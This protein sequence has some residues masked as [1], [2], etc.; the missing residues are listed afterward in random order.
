MNAEKLTTSPI[1]TF[2]ALS[3]KEENVVYKSVR[4]DPFKLYGLYQPK[5]GKR[6]CRM[7]EEVAKKV[8]DG[9]YDL[10][11]KTAGGRVR[12]R[13]DSPFIALRCKL[14]FT[15]L[16]PHMAPTGQCGF[17]LYLTNE[18]G[19]DVFRHAFK[20]AM[21]TF[22]GYEGCV[23][24]QDRKMRDITINFP[25]FANVDEVWIG[26]LP[27]AEL[28]SPKPYAIEKPVV[29]YGSS[30]THGGCA[31]RPGL[32]YEAWI[33]RRLNC[34]YI[35]LGFSGNC[36]GEPVM[37]EY[38]AK[39]DASVFVIDYDHNAPSAEHL[40]NTHEP[41]YRAIR[42][43]H[44]DTP[45][46]FVSK[47]D[48]N[49]Q[50]IEQRKRREVIMNTYLKGRLEGDEN[51]FFVDGSTLFGEDGREE[52][53]VDGTHPND[54]GFMRMADHIGQAVKNALKM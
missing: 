32:S 3:C 50:D 1:Y 9:V 2:E 42:A 36:K 53:T 16:M 5:Q 11:W 4:E 18:E 23:N 14:P 52:C 46:V 10:I 51:L 44:P 15:N 29:F 34:D 6:F 43:L 20:P 28:L 25:L 26:L 31:S 30:I 27:G 38:L 17:D 37:A 19:K 41:I 47:P 33:S 7:D 12:F 49:Y 48:Y 8:S 35:N 21:D 54:I 24:F 13:T 22:E 39:M 40:Q 45:I